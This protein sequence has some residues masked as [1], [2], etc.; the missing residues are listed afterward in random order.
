MNKYSTEKTVNVLR[1]AVSHQSEARTG[2][3]MYNTMDRDKCISLGSPRWH[4][5]RSEST[6]TTWWHRWSSTP[7]HD[8]YCMS[9]HGTVRHITAPHGTAP[10]GAAQE[11]TWQR[12][13]CCQQTMWDIVLIQPDSFVWIDIILKQAFYRDILHYAVTGLDWIGLNCDSWQGSNPASIISAL[14]NELLLQPL[15]VRAGIC[16]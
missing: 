14:S 7:Q 10:H 8:K 3:H 16:M 5:D 4:R 1:G 9:L 15:V 12:A 13:N 11:S 2:L 6:S